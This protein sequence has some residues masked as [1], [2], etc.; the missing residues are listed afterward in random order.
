LDWTFLSVPGTLGVFVRVAFVNTPLPV[1]ANT[2][3]LDN[4]GDWDH[5]DPRQAWARVFAALRDQDTA[6]VNLIARFEKG[7]SRGSSNA[8]TLLW[9]NHFW[10]RTRHLWTPDGDSCLAEYAKTPLASCPP[11]PDRY[12][13]F[14]KIGDTPL[15][16]ARDDDRL[17][18]WVV[19]WAGDMAR[20][21]L[22]AP[23]EALL[24]VSIPCPPRPERRL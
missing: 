4:P 17:P 7:D 19:P 2:L 8:P 21:L 12:D 18:P 15:S 3:L 14:M 24:P 6:N 22:R 23:Y 11:A 20:R 1:L 10:C 9:R 5:I 16:P 13:L